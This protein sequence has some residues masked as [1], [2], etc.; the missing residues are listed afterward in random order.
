MRVKLYDSS[1]HRSRPICI[2]RTTS[3]HH[4]SPPNAR[5]NRS[6]N[7]SWQ[8]QITRFPLHH[9]KYHPRNGKK[10]HPPLNTHTLPSPNHQPHLAI[11]PKFHSPSLPQ[12]RNTHP[13][14]LHES[15]RA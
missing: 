12:L 9:S 11:S 7:S 3:R 4:T 8:T 5:E 6:N 2:T 10:L 13:I 14:F 1:L 15:R